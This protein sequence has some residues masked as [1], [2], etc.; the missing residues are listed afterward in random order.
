MAAWR[1][2]GEEFIIAVQSFFSFGFMPTG[3]NATILTL[4]PKVAEAQ[5]MK[6]YRPIA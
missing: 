2:V 4:I 3:I 6:E 1:V 5:T